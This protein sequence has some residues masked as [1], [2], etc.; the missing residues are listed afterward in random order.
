MRNIANGIRM[1][2]DEALETLGLTV[3]YGWSQLRH[4]YAKTALRCHPD[5]V[6]ITGGDVETAHH[7]MVRVNRA[8][9]I[10]RSA[11]FYRTLAEGLA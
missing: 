6:G 7:R 9:E 3:D 11:L 2:L 4:A 1:T 10:L 8:Y 5:M